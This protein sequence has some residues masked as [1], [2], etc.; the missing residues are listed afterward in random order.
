MF[1]TLN[2]VAAEG[3][4]IDWRQIAT[5]LPGRTNK[6]CRKRWYNAVADGINKGQ[7]TKGEDERLKRGVESHGLK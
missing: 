5:K 3:E 7:W 2:L 6:D 1:S 4:T